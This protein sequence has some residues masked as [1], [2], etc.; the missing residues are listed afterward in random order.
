MFPCYIFALA[1]MEQKTFGD[2]LPN[3]MQQGVQMGAKC[4]IQQCWELL[5]NNVV[6]VCV[7]L[8]F[9]ILILECAAYGEQG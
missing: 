5:A 4:N 7:R 9:Q 8:N 2:L 3:N 1:I 6:S